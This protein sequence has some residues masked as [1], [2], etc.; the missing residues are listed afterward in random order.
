[1]RCYFGSASHANDKKICTCETFLRRPIILLLLLLMFLH[2]R[3]FSSP[4]HSNK[5]KS[6]FLFFNLFTPIFLLCPLVCYALQLDLIFFGS[7]IVSGSVLWMAAGH[8]TWCALL[9]VTTLSLGEALWIPRMLEYAAILA[10][11]GREGAY[12]ALCDVPT[13]LAK[14]LVGGMSGH[15]LEHHCSSQGLCSG[16]ALW[17]RIFAL[18]TSSPV[19]MFLL[20]GMIRGTAT[21]VGPYNFSS[22]DPKYQITGM[23]DSDDEGGAKRHDMGAVSTPSDNTGDIESISVISEKI[24]VDDEHPDTDSLEELLDKN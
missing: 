23:V 8:H 18:S 1:V 17:T 2:Y 16:Q 24:S 19:F 5:K 10:P 20:R 22:D 4:H 3:V 12:M 14:V 11:K 7:I 13:F 15:L 21:Q 6:N 9:F